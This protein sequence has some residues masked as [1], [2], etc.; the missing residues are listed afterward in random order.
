MTKTSWL[1]RGW[2]RNRQTR[3]REASP[4]RRKL[5][6]RP[7]MEVREPVSS[8]AGRQFQNAGR[9]ISVAFM[10]TLFTWFDPAPSK[11]RG[12]HSQATERS[13]VVV[14]GK[15]LRVP[16]R[17]S[18]A[19]SSKGLRC[20]DRPERMSRRRCAFGGFALS[21]AGPSRACQFRFGFIPPPESTGCA[22]RPGALFF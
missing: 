19:R 21:P 9:V 8:P 14:L 22:E 20:H 6:S 1:R 17:S 10:L 3:V 12:G 13:G 5:S 4:H 11:L 2:T 7:E 16:P 15:M 18:L